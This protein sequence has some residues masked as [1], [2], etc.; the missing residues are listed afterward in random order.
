[1]FPGNKETLL[2]N[3]Q[4]KGKDVRDELLKFHEKYYSSN[5]MA[6]S[7]IGRESLDELTEMVTEYFSD[8]VNKNVEV[9]TFD[10]SPYRKEDMTVSI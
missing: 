10:K 3:P 5:I 7:V 4:G 1:M 2:L 6:L 8:A 9:P